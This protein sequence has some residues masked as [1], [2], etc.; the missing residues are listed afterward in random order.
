[1]A[2]EGPAYP[3]FLP[4]VMRYWRIRC[5]NVI[6]PILFQKTLETRK[7]K[8]ALQWLM[9]MRNDRGLRQ[10]KR[11]HE[12]RDGCRHQENKPYYF[13]F[14]WEILVWCILSTLGT[15]SSPSFALYVRTAILNCPFQTNMPIF[16]LP[17]LF[18]LVLEGEGEKGRR[19]KVEMRFYTIILNT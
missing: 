14:M 12:D 3:C 16:P 9:S 15:F 7:R 17:W 8:Q 2:N 18:L 1:M 19:N 11:Q 6:S 5:K 10:W 13:L 4:V